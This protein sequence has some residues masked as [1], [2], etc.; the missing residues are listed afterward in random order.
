[1]PVYYVVQCP[2]EERRNWSYTCLWVLKLNL[3]GIIALIT[4]IHLFS[5]LSASLVVPITGVMSLYVPK[6]MP[7]FS[8]SI[9]GRES[10]PSGTRQPHNPQTVF[11]FSVIS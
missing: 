10:A 4:P 3:D 8:E 11:T 9:V 1:M 5:P 2:K 7:A 6:T